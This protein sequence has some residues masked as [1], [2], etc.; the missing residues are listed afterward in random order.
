MLLSGVR[1][2]LLQDGGHQVALVGPWLALAAWRFGHLLLL[3]LLVGLWEQPLAHM[4]GE[5]A[6]RCLLPHMLEAELLQSRMLVVEAA[7]RPH[8]SWAV[9][10][11]RWCWCWCWWCQQL[12]AVLS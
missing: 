8:C 2:L 5:Q 10:Q 12:C 7:Q 11:L 9:L 3:L 1:R 6:G 4:M